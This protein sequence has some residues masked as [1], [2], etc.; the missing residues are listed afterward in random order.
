M[1]EKIPDVAKY[2][3]VYGLAAS[4]LLIAFVSTCYALYWWGKERRFSLVKVIFSLLPLSTAG[5]HS[6]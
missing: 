1:A 6:L 4:F 5:T 3:V 2:V